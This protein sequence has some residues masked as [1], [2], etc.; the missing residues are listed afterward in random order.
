LLTPFLL[1]SAIMQPSMISAVGKPPAQRN[2]LVLWLL[3][4]VVCYQAGYQVYMTFILGQD[5]SPI[6]PWCNGSQGSAQTCVEAQLFQ[7]WQSAGPTGFRDALDLREQTDG[8]LVRHNGN[9]SKAASATQPLPPAVTVQIRSR[10]NFTAAE[11]SV[12]ATDTENMS[13]SQHLAGAS[14]SPWSKGLIAVQEDFEERERSRR[15]ARAAKLHEKVLRS[16]ER[17]VEAA[18]ATIKEWQNMSKLSRDLRALH[19]RYGA[20][21]E[22]RRSHTETAK[23]ELGHLTDWASDVQALQKHF[24]GEFLPHGAHAP[25]TTEAPKDDNMTAWSHNLV[26][27]QHRLEARMA[28]HDEA[29]HALEAIDASI[30]SHKKAHPELEGKIDQHALLDQIAALGRQMCSDQEHQKNPKCAQFLTAGSQPHTSAAPTGTHPHARSK[31]FLAE[32]S[33]ASEAEARLNEELH[34]L[35]DKQ[36]AWETS[37]VAKVA[38]TMKDFCSDPLHKNQ[39]TCAQFLQDASRSEAADAKAKKQAWH[40]QFASKIANVGQ[41]LCSDPAR[42]D[43]RI[44]QQILKDKEHARSIGAKSGEGQTAEDDADD[45]DEVVDDAA[46]V[47]AHSSKGRIELH[48]SSVV[49]WQKHQT[50]GHFLASP[51][52]VETNFSLVDEA[53]VTNLRRSA[54]WSGRVPSVACVTLVPKGGAAKAWMNYFIDNFRLQKY[55]GTRQLVLVYQ[56]DDHEAAELV[57]KY[58]DGSYILSAVARGDDFPSAAAFRFGAWLA[59]DADVVARWDFEAWHHPQR[60]SMQVR[61]LAFSGRPACLLERWTVLDK[62]GANTTVQD[63]A[64]WD[65]SL[66]GEAAWMRTNWYPYLAEERAVFNVH[67]V[68]EVVKLDGPGLEVFDES[69]VQ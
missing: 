43:Y 66:V 67:A 21:I 47:A 52:A 19:D 18:H 20:R 16:H 27:L 6:D 1:L 10:A 65:S 22:E 30:E 13:M 5:A 33:A 58:A 60:L 54:H 8:L 39:P 56:H 14:L 11:E 37:F 7:G 42:K 17:H 35:A 51:A 26:D 53:Q 55:E 12:L 45:E 34:Q 63:G 36:K 4:L 62:A 64:R 15:E 59:R 68:R 38:D 32:R 48:W 9:L 25:A 50:K 69:H 40:N 29:H 61:A 46:S 44:C 41:E 2:S 23:D 31:H 3:I 49:E 28:A 57:H 24:E